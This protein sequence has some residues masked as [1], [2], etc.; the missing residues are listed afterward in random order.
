MLPNFI[1]GGAAA[2]GTSFLGSAVIQHPAVYLPYPMEPECHYF[3]K[4]W[5]Y[6]RGLDYY[7]Q[8]WFT[9]VQGQ[10]AVGERSSSYL[11]GGARVAERIHSAVPQA[12]LIFTL[13]NPIER[14]WANYRFTVLQGLEHLDFLDALEREPERVATETGR[15]AEIQPHDY[16]GRGLYAAQ[17]EEFLTLFPAEQMLILKSEAMSADPTSEIRRVFTF[18]NVDPSFAPRVP[19]A[20]TSLNVRDPST[21]VR[22]R[23]CLGESF[24]AVILSIREQQDPFAAIDAAD[25]AKREAVEAIVSNLTDRKQPMDATAR[26]FLRARFADDIRRLRELV[27]FSLDDWS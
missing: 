25:S 3:L 19:P 2:A 15:W 7:Q 17:L 11:F 22:A 14:A 4:S 18:L 1:I 8:R 16:T 21:Q 24:T 9:T 12:K 20:F 10:T 6:D 26:N 5:E 13:R 23:Q 27:D